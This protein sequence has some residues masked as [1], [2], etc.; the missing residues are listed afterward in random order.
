[1]CAW[2]YWIFHAFW[3]PANIKDVP[4]GLV[5]ITRLR[6]EKINF[7]QVARPLTVMTDKW[8][9]KCIQIAKFMCV[10]WGMKFGVKIGL[11]MKNVQ[12]YWHQHHRRHRCRPCPRQLVKIALVIN[13]MVRIWILYKSVLRKNA[14]DM[15]EKLNNVGVRQVN[16]WRT[17]EWVILWWL[18]E[19]EFAHFG[20]CYA[21]VLN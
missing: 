6:S 5:F 16:Q 2:I 19:P 11:K 4:D 3:S 18:A 15:F 20:Y 1:M 9:N 13:Q 14:I 10:F 7:I 21:G 8:K 17:N 12:Q